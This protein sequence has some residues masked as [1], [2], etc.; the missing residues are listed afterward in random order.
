[1]SL[2]FVVAQGAPAVAAFPAKL[3]TLDR[4]RK[5]T[6]DGTAVAST[7]IANDRGLEGDKS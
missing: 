3:K 1:M 6:P 7:A 5:Q 4:L 2:S